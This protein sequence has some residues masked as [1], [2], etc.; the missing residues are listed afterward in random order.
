MEVA[1]RERDQ[2]PEDAERVSRIVKL[3]AG[4]SVLAK[5]KWQLY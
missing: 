5:G 2:L 1:G 4:I 3:V